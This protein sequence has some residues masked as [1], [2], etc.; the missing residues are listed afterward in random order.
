[1]QELT[2]VVPV[3]LKAVVTDTLRAE[4][5]DEISEGIEQIDF[6][7]Q[8]IEFQ[9]RRALGAVERDDLQAAIALRGR[10]EEEKKKRTDA[11]AQLS[12]RVQEVKQLADGSEVARGNVQALMTVKP[13]ADLAGMLRTEMVVKDGI[14]QEIRT[15]VK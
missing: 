10:I 8:Q 3:T 14:V 1:M 9:G 15:E 13:G 11:K 7:L 5:I 12:T 4:L 2:L 6:E